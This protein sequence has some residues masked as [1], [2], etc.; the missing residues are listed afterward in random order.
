M[1][2]PNTNAHGEVWTKEQ[3]DAVWQKGKYKN[4]HD[5]NVWR[6]D[7]C[8]DLMYRS[9]HGDRNSEYGWEIDHINPVS[10]DGTDDISNLQPL[11]WRNNAAKGNSLNWSC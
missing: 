10:N 1:R 8:S 4:D 5:P 9:F 2:K 11:N 6:A 3:I 7:K